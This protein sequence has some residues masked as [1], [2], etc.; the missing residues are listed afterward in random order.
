M[1][2]TMLHKTWKPIELEKTCGLQVYKVTLLHSSEFKHG[3]H[4]VL[5]Q[6]PKAKLLFVLGWTSIYG[7]SFVNP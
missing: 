1:Q 4:Y 5:Q 6:K 2:L 7:Q 3:S